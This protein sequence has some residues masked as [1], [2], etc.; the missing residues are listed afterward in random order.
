MKSVKNT[1]DF[2]LKCDKMKELLAL[3]QLRRGQFV[4]Q[5]GIA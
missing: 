1:V 2:A 4:V 5:G 3:A